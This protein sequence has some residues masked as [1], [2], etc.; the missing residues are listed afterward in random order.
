M[1]DPESFDDFYAGSV[2]RVIS[3]LYAMI[4]DRAEAEDVVQEAYTRA[5]ERWAKIARYADPESWVRTVAWRISVSSWR[6]AR[7][8]L[9]AHRRDSWPDPV[10]E[11]SPD[12]V[13]MI[14]ALR[15]FNADQRRAVVL[16]HLVGLSGQEIARETGAS[17]AAVKARLVRGRQALAAQ[18]Q[19]EASLHV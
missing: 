17:P 1:R 3:Q 5:W 19:E 10:P 15:V 4:G 9:A 12:Y 8:R 16:Y 11:V 7:S 6:K 2:G 18:L 13:A 14:S